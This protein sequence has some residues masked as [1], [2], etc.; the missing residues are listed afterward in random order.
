MT[1]L[2]GEGLGSAGTLHSVGA[3]REKREE[4]KD[5]GSLLNIVTKKVTG[6]RVTGQWCVGVTDTA[7]PCPGANQGWGHC[8]TVQTKDW[9]CP[10]R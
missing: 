10:W 6:V 9:V 3:G 1:A 4:G 5:S 2:P 7:G 8:S